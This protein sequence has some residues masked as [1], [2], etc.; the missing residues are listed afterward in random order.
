MPVTP[1]DGYGRALTTGE[2]AAMEDLA[3]LDAASAIQWG[4]ANNDTGIMI[5]A[6][7]TLA[8]LRPAAPQPR[9]AASFTADDHA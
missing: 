2:T 5:R 9:D 7:R 3:A 8:R 1:F 6:Y 4:S